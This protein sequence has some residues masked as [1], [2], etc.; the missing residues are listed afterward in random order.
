MRRSLKTLLQSLSFLILSLLSTALLAQEPA[1]NLMEVWVFNV[2]EGQQ[3][4]FEAAFKKQ[5]ELRA[6]HNDPR[7]WV[8]YVPETGTALNRYLLRTCCFAWADQDSYTT[9]TESSP[10]LMQQWGTEVSPHVESMSRY[11][12]E[13]DTANS[14]WPKPGSASAKT[15]VTE[16]A[17]ASGKVSQFHQARAELSQIALNQGWSA[18]GRQWFW[19]DRIGGEPTSVLVVPFENFAAMGSDGPS[20]GSFLTENLG[21]EKAAALMEKFTSS[22]SS[23]NYTI[24]TQRPDLSSGNE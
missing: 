7:N 15:G 17:I 8:V 16:F 3:G 1:G 10:E 2:K 21:A 6:Q 5:G 20:I 12:Y 13:V 23:S 4:A 18:A 9:W 22:V 14:N 19:F 11:F 24:W